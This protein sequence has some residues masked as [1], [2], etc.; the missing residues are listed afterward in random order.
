MNQAHDYTDLLASDPTR[1]TAPAAPHGV[2]D[3]LLGLAAALLLSGFLASCAA[4][5]RLPL[6]AG[7]KSA[8]HDVRTRTVEPYAAVR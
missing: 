1:H 5:A 3:L 6:Q 8:P 4:P 7:V 2:R